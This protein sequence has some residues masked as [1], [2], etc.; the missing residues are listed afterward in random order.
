MI[1]HPASGNWTWNLQE[2]K[3][4]IHDAASPPRDYER[5]KD[6][7]FVFAV[8]TKVYQKLCGSFRK[9]GPIA[10]YANLEETE[11]PQL[12]RHCIALTGNAR[13]ASALRF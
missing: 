6:Y 2:D 11:I 4:A 10:G 12:Q 1:S 7:L 3:E 13:E 8:S 5:L 9:E